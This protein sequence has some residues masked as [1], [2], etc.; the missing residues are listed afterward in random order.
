MFSCFNDSNPDIGKKRKREKSRE[1][2]GTI[3]S[4]AH[5]NSK[6]NNSLEIIFNKA[7]RAG[8]IYGHC[9]LCWVFDQGLKRNPNIYH[10]FFS[11]HKTHSAPAKNPNHPVTIS[12]AICLKSLSMPGNTIISHPFSFSFSTRGY[13]CGILLYCQN[14]NINRVLS[15]AHYE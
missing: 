6:M 4:C 9:W 10:H 11:F 15:C 5:G 1:E 12:I 2:G 14:I 13:F 3:Y 7:E 8:R